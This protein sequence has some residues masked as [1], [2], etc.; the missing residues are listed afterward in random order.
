MLRNQTAEPDNVTEQKQELE[1]HVL[2]DDGG[3]VDVI[4]HN[5]DVTPMEFVVVVLRT[6]FE[7]NQVAAAAVMLRAHYGGKAVVATLP[8]EEAKHRVGRAHGLARS[9]GY[10]LTFTIEP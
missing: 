6:V 10:P 7:L 5:D 1:W 8:R 3:Q 9:A 4:I 2:E